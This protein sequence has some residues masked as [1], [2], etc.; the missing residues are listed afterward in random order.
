MPYYNEKHDYWVGQVKK[1]AKGDHLDFLKDKPHWKKKKTKNPAW[2][3]R[4]EKSGFERKKDAVA[5]EVHLLKEL[6][7]FL[8]SP[9]TTRVT[10]S[11]VST[12]HLDE[13]EELVTGENT[14]KDRERAILEIITFWSEDKPLPMKKK[15]FSTI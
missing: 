10:F 1:T 3:Y 6:D 9:R 15:M 7:E 8:S 11:E 5:W 13:F 12:K 2:L 14:Y 4:K